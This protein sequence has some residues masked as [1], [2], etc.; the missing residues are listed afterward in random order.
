M[1]VL[2]RP[3]L[4]VLLACALAGCIG[5]ARYTA[6]TDGWAVK[7][8]DGKEPPATLIARDGTTCH[9]THRRFEGVQ[10]GDRVACYWTGGRGTGRRP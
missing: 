10:L 7:P 1:E 8:V 3:G 5:P 4:V 6:G 2:M 9:V